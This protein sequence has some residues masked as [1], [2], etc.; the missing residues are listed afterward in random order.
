MAENKM[1]MDP[2]VLRTTARKVETSAGD[3]RKELKRFTSVI[4]GLS[5]TWSSEV[6]DRFCK[7]TRRTGRLFWKWQSSTQ[8]WQK[9]SWGSPMN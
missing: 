6:K 9:D 5:S 8:K 2:E 7:I 3:V 1:E 4:E